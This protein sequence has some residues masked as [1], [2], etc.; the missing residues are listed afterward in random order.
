MMVSPSSFAW[1]RSVACVAGWDGPMLMSIGS[2]C[3]SSFSSWVC[4]MNG[5]AIGPL[6]FRPDRGL[7]LR[8]RVILPERVPLEPLVHED[9]LQVRVAAE[10]D[11]VHVPRLPLVPVDAGPHGHRRV[12]HGVVLVEADLDP[13][14]VLL[15]QRIQMID[16]LEARLLAEVVHPG[17]VH[18]E[19][20]Q[21]LRVV[22]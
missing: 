8:L 7:A 14:P 18:G 20:E 15:L 1:N 11:A 16:D 3:R 5:S 12:D 21:Q 9:P 10:D 6:L 4:M 2:A 17:Q 22:P 19:V 13:D